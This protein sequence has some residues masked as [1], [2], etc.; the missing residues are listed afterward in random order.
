MSNIIMKI[1]LKCCIVVE[2]RKNQLLFTVSC[3]YGLIDIQPVCCAAGS[4][5]YPKEQVFLS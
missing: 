4:H 5:H 3:S 2:V 1:F